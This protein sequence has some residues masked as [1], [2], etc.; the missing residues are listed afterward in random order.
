MAA[1]GS[2]HPPPC[3]W[4]ELCQS[5]P[6]PK[7]ATNQC[8]KMLQGTRDFFLLFILGEGGGRG[9]L[10]H[11]VKFWPFV[12]QWKFYP[13]TFNKTSI[14]SEEVKKKCSIALSSCR[15]QSTFRKRDRFSVHQER[16][17]NNF[18][19]IC[20]LPMV[21]SHNSTETLSCPWSTGLSSTTVNAS[22]SMAESLLRYAM[23]GF[24]AHH[25]KFEWGEYKRDISPYH[26][27]WAEVIMELTSSEIQVCYFKEGHMLPVH[28][29]IQYYWYW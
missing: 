6:Q 19:G 18:H 13:I 11:P 25:G 2:W 20:V 15:A 26:K 7:K 12:S 9:R 21:K 27:R 5:G 10:F 28:L 8:F 16:L 23:V 17:S 4:P 24:S 3:L 22:F 1:A 29:H 14:Q